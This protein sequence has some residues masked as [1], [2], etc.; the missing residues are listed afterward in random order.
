MLHL[1]FA[2]NFPEDT[3]INLLFVYERGTINSQNILTNVFLSGTYHIIV[4]IY[5][6][7][8]YKIIKIIK[9]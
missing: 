3:N 4:N 8:E 2:Q 7:D 5:N 6:R 1:T 9:L